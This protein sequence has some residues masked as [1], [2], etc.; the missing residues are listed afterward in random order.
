MTTNSVDSILEALEKMAEQKE[1]LD[2]NVWVD[3]ASK[4]IALLGNEQDKL[5]EMECEV[6]KIKMLAMESG[7]TASK[8]KVRAE[9]TEEFKN[10]RKLKAKIERVFEIIRISK[11]R[12]RM[13]MEEY[14]SN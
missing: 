12:A 2:P 7:D 14:K 10:T 11:L 5:F 3:G 6:A 1:A 9:A 8:A 4:L 13:S